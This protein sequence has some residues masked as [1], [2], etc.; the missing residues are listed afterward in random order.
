[1]IK[2]L[3]LLLLLIMLSCAAQDKVKGSRNVKTEQFNLTPFHSIQIA[4][5][6]EVGVLKGPRPMMEVK[7]DDNLIDLIQSEVVDG[8]LYIKPIKEFSRAKS[9]KIQITFDDTLKSIKISDKVE[10]ESEQ[11][12]YVEDF[13]LE[14]KNN[15]RVYLTVTAN[16]FNFINGDDAKAELNVTAKQSY[17]QLNQSSDVKALVN[18]PLFK[19]DIYEKASARLEGDVQEFDFRADQSSKFDGEN[20]TAVNATVLAQG[21]SNNQ[22]NVAENLEISA[23]G[24]SKTEIYNTPQVNLTQF[25]D[26][27]VIE[28]KE[29]KKGIF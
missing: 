26:E 29:S 28:K 19:V 1:M 16:S 2:K 9:Q 27:A 11:D 25:T 3:P 6:F 7:A 15:S 8:V 12:L 24:N 14:T 22:I 4:G 10:L 23:Q 18:T 13:Q 17:F 5:E 21:R 20:L